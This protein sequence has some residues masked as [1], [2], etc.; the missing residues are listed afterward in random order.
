MEHQRDGKGI[1]GARWLSGPQDAAAYGAPPAIRSHIERI[2][3]SSQFAQSERISR[4]LR[5][6]VEESLAGRGSQLKEYVI[7]VEVFDRPDSYDPRVD[8]IVRVEAR[9]LRRKL[10][11]YYETEG[12]TEPIR[13]EF[14]K[15]SYVPCVLSGNEGFAA[16]EDI[17]VVLPFTILNS[18]PENERFRDGLAEELIHTFTKAGG[19]RLTAYCPV[20]P[21]GSRSQGRRQMNA[22][23]ILSGSI[24]RE[25][26]HLRI[27]VQLVDTETRFYLWSEVYDLVTSDVFEVQEQLARTIANEARIKLASRPQPEFCADRV[28][29]LN[30]VKSMTESP[31]W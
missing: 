13:I 24:R 30:S 12:R 11:L 2:L 7:G 27:L 26:D 9:R 4:F 29:Y 31:S 14:P 21:V 6:A 16:R 25:G 20:T 28:A 10:R 1:Y 18:G 17:L 3:G 23:V 8:P 5:F 19:L 22:T 15:G